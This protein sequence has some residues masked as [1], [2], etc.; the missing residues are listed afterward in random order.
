MGV[1]FTMKVLTGVKSIPDD[2]YYIGQN[3]QTSLGQPGGNKASADEAEF[4]RMVERHPPEAQYQEI[5]DD[6]PN[7]ASQATSTEAL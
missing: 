4:T 2:V 7:S 1:D 6:Q 5:P 3:G